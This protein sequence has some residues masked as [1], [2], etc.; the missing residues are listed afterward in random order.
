MISVRGDVS[1]RFNLKGA[2]DAPRK[3]K[4]PFPFLVQKASDVMGVLEADGTLRYVS[5]AVENMIGYKPEEL[6]GTKVLEYVHPD[7]FERVSDAL[8]ETLETSGIL[9][10]MAFRARCA[11]G[12]WRHVEVARNN[13][14]NDPNVGGVVIDVR[15]ITEHVRV[16]EELR[17]L[18]RDYEELLGSVEAI[19]WR[20]DARTLAF[21]FVS[22]QAEAILG[23]PAKRWTEEPSFWPDHIHPEDREWALSFC[24]AATAE[25]RSHS[26]EYRMIAADGSVVW[27]RDIVHVGVEN[28]VPTQLF[29]VMVDITERKEAEEAVVRLGRRNEL[30]L[31]SAGEGIYGLDQGGRTTFVNPAA[32]TMTG[33]EVDELIGK[34]QHEAIH[35]SHSDGTPYPKEECPIY[36]V[37]TDGKIRHVDNEVFWRKDGT[38][39]PVD[40]TSTPIWEDGEVIGVVVT[41]TDITERKEAEE[42]YRTVVEEQT[43]LVCRF[44]PDLTLTF[45]NDA[46]CRYFGKKHEE[47]IGTSFMGHIPVEDRVYYEEQLFRLSKEEPT[48]TVEHRVFTPDGEIRWQQWT[49]RATFDGEGRLVECQSVGRDVTERKLAE[50][51]LK[52]SEER[53]RA[54]MAQSVEAI[55]LFDA[56]T[57]RILESNAAFRRLMGYAEEELLDMRIYDFIAHDKENIDRHVRRSLEKKRRHIGE[58]RY[59]RKDGSVIVVDTSASVISYGGR[60]ALCAVSRDVT[61][62]KEAEERL[63]TSEER[64]AEAQRLAHLGSWEW[65]IKTDEISWSDEVYR[66]YGLV[67][68]S[69][70][71]S[72]GRFM[73]V[74][75][76]DDRGRVKETID[77]ALHG[78]G[79][80][81]VE[82]RV[83]RPDGEVRVVHRRAEV[84]RGEG[85]EPLKMIGT[86][87]DITERK[88]LEERLEHRA[89]YDPLTGLPN[90]YLFTDRLGQALRRTE[91]RAGST[92]AML[93]MDLDGFKAIN[94][95]LGHEMGDQLLI[96]VAERLESCL[97]SEDTLARFGGDEFVVLLEGIEVPNRA[98][99]VAERITA[100]FRAPIAV[101][102]RDLYVKASIGISLRDARTKSPEDLLR[103]ADTAMYRAKDEGIDYK[104]F[105][106]AMHARAVNRL[107]LENDLRRAIEREEF[108]VHYQPIVNLQTGELWG[109]EALV[110][111]DHPERG[112]LDPDEFVPVAEES[113]LVVPMG[114]LVL[115][116][117]CRRAVEWQREFPRTPPLAMSV[118][119]SGRQ[120]RR[121]DLH[122]V[123]GRALKESG[124]SASSLGLDITETVY[125][126][127]LDANAAA[128]DRLKALGIRIS[129]DDFGT[130]YSSV[131]YL[132][133]L[134]ANILKIDKTF[135]RGLGVEVEDTAIMQSIVDLAHILGM[136]V[137]AEGVEVEEQETLLKEMGCDMAQGFHF[138]KPLPPDEVVGFLSG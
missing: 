119:L 92:V 74:V 55:Y 117:A 75:H 108:I 21:T 3:S 106:E 19:I 102:G 24:K 26:F 23:Y 56:E 89:F 83:V 7:D 135:T 98:V 127:A 88:I 84:V 53:Y 36:T 99:Q 59:R 50:E 109:L 58:R 125:I 60:T 38:S 124:L 71:P 15:D 77:N 73:E 87:H 37:L 70:V 52:E 138:A 136:E 101:D 57:K 113:G 1:E 31:N 91:R 49:D 46:Y 129:L 63:R 120:L 131:S 39:F 2:E 115:E 121:P 94:D 118:N 5:P 96:A 81:D 123:I 95:S 35:H 45:V 27:L 10:S 68:Q 41:F 97:R 29:G 107:E 67:P 111:W 34:H 116:E 11:D 134:P 47:L 13:L 54:V 12:S 90:R 130:G 112:L 82:H 9:P 78:N 86:A 17:A 85:G 8:T 30:I 103:S 132:K 44:L 33:F 133:R 80:Y 105:D 25:K 93:F 43:E 20:G 42:R 18:K 48:R 76:P 16:E 14:L 122:E 28:S 114:E 6:I 65:D 126:S 72:F 22:D 128:L 32:A 104:M 62:R 79:P 61:E 4:E 66:I 137:V 40:Y 100:G 64:L 110:R 51:A 69:V